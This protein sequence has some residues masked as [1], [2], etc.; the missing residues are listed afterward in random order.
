MNVKKILESRIRGWFPHEPSLIT[1]GLQVNNEYKQPP[2]I[3]PP[4]YNASATKLLGGY[5]IFWIIFYGYFFI[6]FFNFVIFNFGSHPVSALQI[7]GWIIAGSAVGVIPHAIVTKNQL[8]RLSKDY[9]FHTNKKDWVLLFV[10]MI[11][12]LCLS[13]LVNVFL[14]SSLRMLLISFYCWG[15]SS[16]LTRIILFAAFEKRENM[17]LMQSWWEST[18]IILLPKPPNSNIIAGGS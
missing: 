2:Q 16:Q 18:T 5:T 9:Q 12:F 10:P 6:Y 4:R 11:L 7:V 15:V 8:S 14:Y 13:S 17:R 3:I 1:K